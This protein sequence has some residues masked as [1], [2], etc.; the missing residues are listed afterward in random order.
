MLESSGI[1]NG[2]MLEVFA[3]P[4]RLALYAAQ[5]ACSGIDQLQLGARRC[6]L[7]HCL[8]DIPIGYLIWVEIRAVTGQIERLDLLGARNQPGLHRLA[9]MHA[10]VVQNQEPLFLAVL[11]Q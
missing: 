11:D 8:L 10:Q 2:R 6:Q 3:N 4:L 9:V 7:G 1:A 5:M